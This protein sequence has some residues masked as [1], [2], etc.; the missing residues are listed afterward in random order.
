MPRFSTAGRTAGQYPSTSVAASNGPREQ[1][2]ALILGVGAHGVTRKKGGILRTLALGSCVALIL[3]HRE[4]KLAGMVHVALPDSAINP[5]RAVDLPGYFAD[6]GV[7]VL[8]RAMSKLVDD[9]PTGLAACLVGGANVLRAG[10]LFSIGEKN[11]AA[12]R[13]ELTKRGF[14]SVM[15]DVGGTISR[16]VQI[17]AATGCVLVTSPGRGSWEVRP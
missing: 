17:D 7:E 1:G 12:L 9:L 14:A 15:E 11:V 16:S 5:E 6:T 4:S 10:S 2:G 8:L 3:H 13:K